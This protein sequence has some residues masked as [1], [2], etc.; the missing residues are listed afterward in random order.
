MTMFNVN[1]SSKQGKSHGLLTSDD[2]VIARL[3]LWNCDLDN[4]IGNGETRRQWVFYATKVQSIKCT[5]AAVN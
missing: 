2:V 4:A 3:D 1:I 5:N